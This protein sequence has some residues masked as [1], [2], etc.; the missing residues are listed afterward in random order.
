MTHTHPFR[1]WLWLLVATL[2]GT[3]VLTG[4]EAVVLAQK[5]K[6]PDPKKE[7]KLKEEP[8]KEIPKDKTPPLQTIKAHALAIQGLHLSSDGKQLVTSSRDRTVKV[9]DLGSGKETQT[10]KGLPTDPHSVLFLPDSKQVAIPSGDWKKDK[11]M[12]VGE[13]RL[14]E[15]ASGKVARTLTGHGGFIKSLAL[16]GDG[17][18]LVSGSED[19]TA[20]VWDLTTGKEAQVLKGHG[21]VVLAVA[22]SHDG[23]KVATACQDKTVK[24]WDA[25]NGKELHTLKGFD[26]EV[27]SVA[28][29]PDGKLAAASADATIK[30]WDSAGKDLQTLKAPEGLWAVRFSP[31]GKYLA[32]GG[33]NDTIKI[34]EAA[35]GKEVAQRNGHAG[36]IVALTFTNDSQRL[37]TGG[38]DGTVQVWPVEKK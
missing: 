26:R 2:A 3:L 11:K 12:F 36:T 29:A 19:K 31:D 20:I 30:I 35:S 28:F 4:L 6:Q 1:P 13:I 38:F 8:K 16:S 14:V 23:S 7:E 5:K 32:A 34:F 24:V 17:K 33:W 15:V 10:I 21:E 37:I 25:G 27:T 9:W 22:I 18:K